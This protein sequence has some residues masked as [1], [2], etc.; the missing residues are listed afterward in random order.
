[1]HEPQWQTLSTQPLIRRMEQYP[2]H[3]RAS[4][5][6]DLKDIFGFVLDRSQSRIVAEGFVG[7]IMDRCDAI[8]HAPLGGVARPEFGDGMR[9]VPFEKT[10]VIFYRVQRK[11]IEIVSIFYGGRDYSTLVG[12][13]K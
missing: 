2:V 3:Y 4:A 11:R 7:R 10:A 13:E 12:T 9:M 5:L 1:M 8:G 6:D